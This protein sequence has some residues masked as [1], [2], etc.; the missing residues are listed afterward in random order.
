ME[1]N[2]SQAVM[3]KS[4][5]MGITLVLNSGL[6]FEELL[7]EIIRKFHESDRFFANS[8]FA[9]S[10]EGRDLLEEEKYRIVDRI[11]E[12]TTVKILCILE[13]DEIRDAVIAQKQKEAEEELA[14]MAQ[15]ADVPRRMAGA[16]YCGSLKP[17]EEI[18][19]D[20]SIVIVGDVPQGA[21]VVCKSSIVVL[22]ALRG[23]A[24]AGMDGTPD[25]FIAALTFRPER[26]NIGGIYGSVP[27]K[28]KSSIFSSRNKTPQALI[29]AASDGIIH[30]SPLYPD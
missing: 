3:I 11:M 1:I 17:G 23:S 25:S 15:P 14:R 5:K 21:K 16:F 18:E 10:F 20:E 12:E 30:I 13:N 28:E 24:Y 27:K 26:Y 8:S 7:E 6:P 19:T 29:A 4:S 22:G 9:I 2:M